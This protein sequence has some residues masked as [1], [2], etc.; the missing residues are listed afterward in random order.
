MG[1]EQDS[2]EIQL[3]TAIKYDITH[4][5][6]INVNALG[7]DVKVFQLVLFRP[8]LKVLFCCCLHRAM[9]CSMDLSD[10]VLEVMS[11]QTKTQSKVKILLKCPS[12]SIYITIYMYVYIFVES[13]FLQ[14]PQ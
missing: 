11:R 8:K 10:L 13:C 3:Q 9:N 14:S 1:E 12:Y 4:I 5:G 2:G 6:K 7:G